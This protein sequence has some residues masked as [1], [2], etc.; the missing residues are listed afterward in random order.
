[1]PNFAAFAELSNMRRGA[2]SEDLSSSRYMLFTLNDIVDDK[3]QDSSFCNVGKGIIMMRTEC[4]EIPGG[5]LGEMRNGAKQDE[6]L[7]LILVTHTELVT[8]RAVAN[9]RISD[10]TLVLNWIIKA[11]SE[12]FGMKGLRWCNVGIAQT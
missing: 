10:R 7:L 5:L 6:H 8:P 1:M 12:M 3:V 4:C 9:G 11:Y 2:V